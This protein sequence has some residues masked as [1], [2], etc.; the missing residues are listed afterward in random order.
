ME[1]DTAGFLYFTRIVVLVVPAED[2]ALAIGRSLTIADAH[3]AAAEI[4][5]AIGAS[6]SIAAVME[7]ALEAETAT[8]ALSQRQ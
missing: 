8:N 6:L 3:V 1:I 2:N 7:A 4:P 5:A